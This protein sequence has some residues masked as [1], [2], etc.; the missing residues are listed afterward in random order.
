MA[1]DQAS[2]AAVLSQKLGE[3]RARI[4]SM[5]T[6]T[7]YHHPCIDGVFAALASYMH[8]S[9]R[10]QQQKRHEG[11]GGTHSTHR[12]FPLSVYK[13]AQ[14]AEL[15]LQARAAFAV[16]PAGVRQHVKLVHM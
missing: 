14:V 3:L 13:P 4:A 7:C 16:A 9:Q 10:Q 12:L 11:Q 8:H 1:T 15:E 6:V 5:P 2:P